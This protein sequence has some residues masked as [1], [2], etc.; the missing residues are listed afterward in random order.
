MDSP[1]A[2]NNDDVYDV[3]IIGAGPAGLA[4]LSAL[5]EPYAI[6]AELRNNGHAVER[7]L[8]TIRLHRKLRVCVID[9]AADGVWMQSW[10]HN[11]DTLRIQHLRSPA[12]G[13][14]DMFDDHALL[15]YACRHGR[16]R[17]DHDL[18]E[19][20]CWDRKDL[21]SLGQTQVGLWKLPSTQLFAD[22]CHDLANSLPH[23]FLQGKVIDIDE[24]SD[25]M[26][27]VTWCG[28]NSDIESNDGLSRYD[29][30]ARNVILATGMAGR[31]IVPRGLSQCPIIVFWNHPQA[32]PD[33]TS[34]NETQKQSTLR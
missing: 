16:D 20:G 21:L 33:A 7:A 13:H 24:A 26:Y 29:T 6:D 14:V 25:G 3:C 10:Q 34:S 30:S 32:F 11:F 9:P 4:C 17:N 8:Q 2:I 12:L 31:P 18:L 23:T 1:S 5:C 28:K 19:S 27:L 15:A 22:F